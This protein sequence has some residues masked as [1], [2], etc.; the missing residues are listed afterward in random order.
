[1]CNVTGVMDGF[2][3]RVEAV[4]W[5]GGMVFWV[6]R[7]LALIA[8]TSFADVGIRFLLMFISKK[9]IKPAR[10]KTFCLLRVMLVRRQVRRHVCHY[11][12]A[13]AGSSAVS[14]RLSIIKRAPRSSQITCSI[15]FRSFYSSCVKCCAVDW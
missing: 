9:I 3:V 15:Y 10:G 1:M 7:L 2:N 6:R 5:N 14:D 12:S 4:L 11:A 13:L 8:A